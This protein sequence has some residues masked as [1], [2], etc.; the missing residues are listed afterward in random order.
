M[1]KIKT[2]RLTMRTWGSEDAEA[3]FRIYSDPKAC[4]YIGAGKPIESLEG[5]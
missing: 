3:A 5:M 2:E 4:E 1:L